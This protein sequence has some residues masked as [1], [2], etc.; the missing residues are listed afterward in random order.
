MLYHKW[1][2]NKKTVTSSYL[3]IT[4]NDKELQRWAKLIKEIRGEQS[5]RAVARQLKVS[6]VA[7]SSW[8][9]GDS[10]PTVDSLDKVAKLQGWDIYELLRYLR[11][12]PFAP[13]IDEVFKLA[14]ALPTHEKLKLAT[15]LLTSDDIQAQTYSTAEQCDNNSHTFNESPMSYHNSS[16]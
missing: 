6:P 12:E 11:D 4:M 16:S 15:M 9:H 10:V 5:L 3:Q 13:D 14:I 2:Y 8:E 1:D 7:I